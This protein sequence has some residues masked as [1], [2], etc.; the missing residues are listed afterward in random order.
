M[1]SDHY[2]VQRE[3]MIAE[4]FIRRGL[5]EPRLLEAFRKVPR[6]LFVPWE[7]AEEAYADYPLQIG[8]NQTIS[9]P[10]IV[11]MMT[12]LLQLDGSETVLEIG[13]G[14]G[15]Q[16]AILGKLARDV[17]S[18]EFIPELAEKAKHRLCE[19]GCSNVH[20]HQGD[21]SCGWP[22]F[23]PYSRILVTAASPTPPQPLLD[24]LAAGGRMVIPIGPRQEQY[25]QVWQRENE[26][27]DYENII[28][29]VFVPLRGKFGW[30]TDERSGTEG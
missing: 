6:H 9:Q 22:E 23:A 14:S 2:A 1:V 11:A 16:S 15:Y 8:F 28:P 29:V 10:Y 19:S 5:H 30:N 17:H 25:L 13:T 3:R 20:V 4:Q 21:G 12:S 24:Q 18:V 26:R 27:L 7:L